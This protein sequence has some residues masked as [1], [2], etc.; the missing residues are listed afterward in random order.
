VL[1]ALATAIPDDQR[2]VVIEDT[3][4]FHLQKPNLLSVECQTDTF[5]ANITFDDLLKSA[6]SRLELFLIRS[7]PATP[8]RSPLSTPIP[9]QRRCADLPISFFAA[10]HRPP[11][12]TLKRR[13]VRP[14]ITWSMWSAS[15]V[16]V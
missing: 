7:T 2:I 8:D 1:R 16:V 3:S 13:S 15:R 4:E 14:S 6:G 12:R 5:K 9:R 10:T 11:S